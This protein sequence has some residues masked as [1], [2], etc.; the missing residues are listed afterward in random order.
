MEEMIREKDIISS[1]IHSRQTM[2]RLAQR[3]R[4]L[5]TIGGTVVPYLVGHV[6]RGVG[7]VRRV[8]IVIV[9]VEK[10][11]ASH[12]LLHFGPCQFSYT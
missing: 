7:H 10:V 9:V 6:L 12:S 1:R 11:S 3:Q 8:V 5:P 4:K 2:R